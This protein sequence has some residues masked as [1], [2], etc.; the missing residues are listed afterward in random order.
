MPDFSAQYMS[1]IFAFSFVYKLLTIFAFLSLTNSTQFKSKMFY[2]S[3]SMFVVQ[4]FVTSK[5][6][7]NKHQML[8]VSTTGRGRMSTERRPDEAS[9]H[10]L[11]CQMLSAGCESRINRQTI[12]PTTRFWHNT[13]CKHGYVSLKWISIRYSSSLCS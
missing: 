9:A 8:V 12:T 6:N 1:L 5:A 7:K 2:L 10:F 3:Y 11:T 4:A 13:P